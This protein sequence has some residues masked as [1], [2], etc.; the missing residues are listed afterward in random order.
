[1]I[2]LF[3][4]ELIQ[5][6]PVFQ[7]RGELLSWLLQNK[8]MVDRLAGADRRF[9]FP[10]VVRA[11]SQ[12]GRLE[13]P[14]ARYETLGQVLEFEYQTHLRPEVADILPPSESFKQSL[15][16]LRRYSVMLKALEAREAEQRRGEGPTREPQ[17][18]VYMEDHRRLAEAL[19]PVLQ[20]L[21]ASRRYL[22]VHVSGS[23]HNGWLPLVERVQAHPTLRE[24]RLFYPDGTIKAFVKTEAGVVESAQAQEVRYRPEEIESVRAV[25]PWSARRRIEK[26]PALLNRLRSESHFMLRDVAELMSSLEGMPRNQQTP[27]RYEQDA[28]VAPEWPALCSLARIYGVDIRELIYSSNRTRHP[29][30]PVREWTASHYPLYLEGRGDV[31][32][33]QY[34]NQHDPLH[35]SLGWLIFS[36]R[37][38]PFR[39]LSVRDVSDMTGMSASVIRDLEMN[40]SKPNRHQIHR[41]AEVLDL[42][43]SRIATLA[44]KTHDHELAEA[45]ESLFP[46]QA[47]YLD[48]ASN[49]R[50][51]IHGYLA[52]ARAGKPS[53]GQILFGHRSAAGFFSAMEYG[54]RLGLPPSFWDHR[55]DNRIGVERHNWHEWVGLF[56]KA[57]IPLQKLRPF[58]EP[59]GLRE[60]SVAYQVALGMEGG[61]VL[62][63]SDRA[64]ISATSL[65]E[66]LKNPGSRVEPETILRLS[67]ALP[68]MDAKELYRRLHPSVG[69]FFPATESEA[70]HLGLE[71]AAVNRAL[72]LDPRR[73]LFRHRMESGIDKKAMGGRLGVTGN[74]IE[75]MERLVTDVR[76]EVLLELSREIGLDRR[77]VYL[78]YRPWI[79]G[80]FPLEKGGDPMAGPAFQEL[81]RGWQGFHDE[82]NMRRR[83]WGV[84]NRRRLTQGGDL[85]EALGDPALA[86]R[87]TKLDEA[88]SAEEILRL[89]AAFPELSAREWYEHFNGA[90]LDYFLGRRVDGSFDYRA[91]SPAIREPEAMLNHLR[92]VMVGQDGSMRQSSIRLG[93]HFLRDA[94]MLRKGLEA[95]NWQEETMARVSLGL[96]I[97]RRLL[98]HYFRAAEWEA[99]ESADR[100]E[101]R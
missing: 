1:R 91:A 39:Y 12:A 41:L 48:D 69:Q 87:L 97:D 44:T 65:H 64:G 30:L 3:Q 29:R 58:L 26:F 23:L 17:R 11:M 100:G 20:S 47:I 56:Q 33:I 99:M 95:R 57:A 94:N 43:P 40:R 38:N 89:K 92:Q 16:A 85:A 2:P 55:E 13:G 68:R 79:L 35:Q 60:D 31:E 63:I 49:E 81:R 88:L 52:L 7:D 27:S 50:A 25:T 71:P 9:T 62:E 76:D 61:N 36:S 21:D 6:A 67:Y 19:D 73:L 77:E 66:L 83:L 82:S 54:E 59:M 18:A 10:S 96:G 78:N 70:P 86:R 46:G 45:L 101:G 51:Q 98:F 93:L 53:I 5:Q 37:K 74:R 84:L 28:T 4:R 72:Q 42:S 80:I 14:I 8:A 24:V 75:H 15:Q 32:R 22:Q 90:R 34:Y